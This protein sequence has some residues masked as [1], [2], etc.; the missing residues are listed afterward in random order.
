MNDEESQTKP[1]GIGVPQ[2]AVL[3]PTLFNIV[4]AP[5]LWKLYDIPQLKATI[6][7]N[8]ITVWTNTRGPTEQ[9]QTIQKG[10]DTICDYLKEVG[11]APSPEKRNTQFS[12]TTTRALT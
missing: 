10:L 3:S 8:D 4:M 2:G 6:Y 12:G 1:N 7:A 11:L 9:K 5:L